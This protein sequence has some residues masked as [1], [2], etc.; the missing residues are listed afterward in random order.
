MPDTASD[1]PTDVATLQAMVLTQK[2]ELATARSGL[3]EQRSR[4][5]QRPDCRSCCA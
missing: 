5:R 3:I 2:A 1:L 4:S